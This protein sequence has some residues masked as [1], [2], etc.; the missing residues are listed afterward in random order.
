MGLSLNMLCSIVYD[1]HEVVIIVPVQL[2]VNGKTVEVDNF[3]R[4]FC[5]FNNIFQFYT[6]KFSVA[7]NHCRT[8]NAY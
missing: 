7:V 1:D 4:G 6:L 3:S 8:L 2:L 5:Y